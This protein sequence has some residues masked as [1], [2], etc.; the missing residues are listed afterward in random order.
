MKEEKTTNLREG[1]NEK[2]FERKKASQT[3]NKTIKEH[4]NKRHNTW[5]RPGQM[6]E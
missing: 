5:Q 4:K 3:G 2:C 1:K 6:K